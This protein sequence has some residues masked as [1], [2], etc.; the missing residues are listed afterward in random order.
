MAIDRTR[1]PTSPVRAKPQSI[2]P[3]TEL[4]VVARLIVEIRSDGSR[5]FARGAMEDPSQGVSVGVEA[6]GATPM[7]LATALAK[8]MLKLPVM[9]TADQVFGHWRHRVRALLP[10]KK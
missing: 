8:S 3:A 9:R 10:G 2:E 7:E 1:K 5:T 4:P 6:E